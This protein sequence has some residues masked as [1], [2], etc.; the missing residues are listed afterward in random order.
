LDGCVNF[1]GEGLI[2]LPNSLKELDLSRTNVTT[3]MQFIPMTIQKL[4]VNMHVTDTYMQYIP[5][6]LKKL[7]LSYCTDITDVGFQYLLNLTSLISLKLTE[8]NI[9]YRTFKLL[10]NNILDIT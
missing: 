7:D 6:F 3:G 10:A 8:T 4:K 1:T 2:F 9:T 5:I